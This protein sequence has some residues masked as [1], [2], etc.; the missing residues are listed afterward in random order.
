MN[1]IV[2]DAPDRPAG[3]DKGRQG[4]MNEKTARS[5]MIGMIS[6]FRHPRESGNPAPAVATG[7]EVTRW[8]PAFAGV[9]VSGR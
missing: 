2:M 3:L 8:G 9:T 4:L 1:D 6:L 5:R 7:D